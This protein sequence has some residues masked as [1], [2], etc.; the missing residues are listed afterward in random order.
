RLAWEFTNSGDGRAARLL[1]TSATDAA[2]TPYLSV[3]EL[4]RRY[5]GVDPDDEREAIHERVLAVASG[6]DESTRAG[7]PALLALLGQADAE[8]EAIDPV[9]RRH[10]TL[11][12]IKRLLL[13]ESRVQPLVVVIEDVHWIDSESQALLD[14]LVTALP[15]ARFFL[16]VT[17]RPEY[18]H[19]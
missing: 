16:V 11:E 12:A 9:E 1:E 17:Y 14:A 3:I 19:G 18:R 10:Q 13:A 6:L 8:W 4:L 5:F 15:T 2:I 7:L